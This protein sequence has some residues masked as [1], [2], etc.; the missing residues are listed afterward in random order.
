MIKLDTCKI[1][2]QP[3]KM[4]IWDLNNPNKVEK[5]KPRISFHNQ[6]NIEEE[7]N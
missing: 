7:W 2:Y 6:S 5:N 1:K 3:K 4:F